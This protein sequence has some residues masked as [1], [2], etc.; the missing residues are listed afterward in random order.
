M[1]MLSNL[2]LT[3]LNGIIAVLGGLASPATFA[4]IVVAAGFASCAR[5]EVEELDRQGGKP[6]IGAH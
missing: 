6:V 5:A 4:I 3:W 1:E 2:L